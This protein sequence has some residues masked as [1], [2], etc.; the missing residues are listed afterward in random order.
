MAL[1]ASDVQ[2]MFIKDFN[3]YKIIDT[4]ANEIMEWNLRKD[5]ALVSFDKKNG[6]WFFFFKF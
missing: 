2:S 4:L 5:Y 1:L 6:N 3:D